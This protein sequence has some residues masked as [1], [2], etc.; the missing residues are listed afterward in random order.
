MNFAGVSGVKG[1]MELNLRAIDRL[2]D[3]TPCRR[4]WTVGRRGLLQLRRKKSNRSNSEGQGPSPAEGREGTIGLTLLG[5]G[6]KIL[7]VG[8]RVIGRNAPFKRFLWA[9]QKRTPGWERKRES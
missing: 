3:K 2:K 6:A 5:E 8:A 4:S 7:G 9:K 1:E